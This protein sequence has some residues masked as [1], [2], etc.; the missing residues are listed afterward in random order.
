MTW[1]RNVRVRKTMRTIFF[2][3]ILLCGLGFATMAV[4]QI[5]RDSSAVKETRPSIIPPAAEKLRSKKPLP[6]DFVP[7]PDRWRDVKT[8]PYEKNVRGR[9][10]DPY[11]QNVLKGDYPILGQNTFLVFTA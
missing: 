1:F 7:L 2:Q 4:G 5:P 10:F 9:W 6:K 11:N 3:H 8:P